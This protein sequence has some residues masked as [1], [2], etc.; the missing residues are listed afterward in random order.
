M[1]LTFLVIG[2]LGLLTACSSLSRDDSMGLHLHA[3]KVLVDLYHGS[4]DPAVKAAILDGGFEL[5]TS[6]L[7]LRD[8]ELQSVGTLLISDNANRSYQ[9]A[10]IDAVERF[11][12]K[13]GTL[14]CAGQAWSWA[15]DKKDI[16]TYPL[17]QLGRRLGFTITGQNIG[18]AAGETSSAYLRGAESVNQT[19]WWPS[20]VQAET[21]RFTILMRDD[22]MKPM[23]IRML[24]GDGQIFIFGH[25]AILNDNPHIARNILMENK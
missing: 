17:N 15:G 23:A 14:I 21:S 25:G 12:D 19:D 7:P 3:N 16:N 20:M 9:S 11:V 5:R 18:K 4:I 13:G 6:D 10:E 1:K 2:S 24:K 8:E 22:K